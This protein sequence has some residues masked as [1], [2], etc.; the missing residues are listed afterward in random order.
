[1]LLSELAGK[2]VAILGFGREG[3]A[4]LQAIRDAG[5]LPFE[6]RT[7]AGQAFTV[8]GRLRIPESR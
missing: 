4:M 8:T 2:R 3:K 6:I 1:M 5:G 7:V